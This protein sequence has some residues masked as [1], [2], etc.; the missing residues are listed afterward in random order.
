MCHNP[1]VSVI[2]PTYGGS[3]YLSKALD[4]FIKQSYTNIEVIVVD[5]NGVGEVEQLKTATIMSEY[6]QFPFIRYVCHEQNIN[7][8]AARNTG[9]RNSSGEYLIF[10]DD[11]DICCVDRIFRQVQ[12]LNRLP[13]SVAA[14]YCSHD[15]FYNDKCIE[16]INVKASGYLLYENLIH[17]MEI[18]TSSIMIKRSC[19]EKLNGFDES[20]RRHQD[21][22]FVCRLS[23][24]YEIIADDFIGYHRILSM[25]FA[26]RN[27]ELA[28]K[29][30]EFFLQKMQPY[31]V[32]FDKK[33][34]KKIYVWNR[35]DVALYYVK[36][37]NL[38]SFFKEIY[39]INGGF[40][41][42]AFLVNRLFHIIQRCK[43]KMV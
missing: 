35:M 42:L 18:A 11:D 2:I 13:D 22:E 19:F 33:K 26:P 39:D 8:S 5:D 14:V 23:A 9:Y 36:N 6:Q 32:R 28:K 29:Y 24:E 1:L 21:W 31:I 17:S 37:H 4:S 16:I 10:F 40:Y 38:S 20:F 25:R 3:H 15:T 34:Q 12:L 41:S 27:A 43:I 7:G 30:R